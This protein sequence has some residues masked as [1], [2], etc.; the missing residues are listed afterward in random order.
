[1]LALLA[2]ATNLTC[3]DGSGAP[4]EPL[5][6]DTVAGHAL[7]SVAS[8]TA[9]APV[10]GSFEASA[11]KV[12]AGTEVTLSWSVTGADSLFIDQGVGTVTGTSTAVTADSTTTYTLMAANA[13]GAA[14]A[15]V[16][17]SAGPPPVINSFSASPAAVA[18]GTEVQLLWDADHASRFSIPG[19]YNYISASFRDAPVTPDATT[20]YTL[21][22]HNTYG[23]DTASVTVKVGTAPVIS[24]LTASPETVA[25]G[26]AATLSW[27]VA[28]ADSL[29]IDPGVG[30]VTGTSAVVTV[31]TTSTYTLTAQNDFGSATGAVTITVGAPPVIHSFEADDATVRAG[32]VVTLSWDATGADSLAI[33]NGVGAVTGTSK[34][35]TVDST[36]TYTLTAWSAFGTD[37]ASVTVAVLPGQVLLPYPNRVEK[38]STGLGILWRDG[39][40]PKVDANIASPDT[41]FMGVW[42]QLASHTPGTVSYEVGDVAVLVHAHT[43]GTPSNDP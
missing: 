39:E 11:S 21:I 27:S 32:D 7:G 12:P 13:L 10:I 24:S 20:T 15:A 16:T 37:T 29:W 8:S 31:D 43:H 14:T 26:G 1:M 33:D 34:G 3:T 41:W 17:V 28:G 5:P 9:S 42:I 35:V 38:T 19:D 36:T 22:A 6:A 23:K 18:P 25:A 4:L 2:A 30:T 40:R